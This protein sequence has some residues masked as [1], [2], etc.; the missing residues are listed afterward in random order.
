MGGRNLVHDC[1][2]SRSIGYFM[3]PL[4]VVGLFAKKP[5]IIKLKGID[6]S[7]VQNKV[8]TV[9]IYMPYSWC[10]IEYLICQHFKIS[11]FMDL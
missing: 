1:G 3:E 6:P 2:L 8:L 4:I 11:I 9:N 5:L 7:A 10:H